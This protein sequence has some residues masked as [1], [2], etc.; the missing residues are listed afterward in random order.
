MD[1]GEVVPTIEG[2][3]IIERRKVKVNSRF[4]DTYPAGFADMEK[5]DPRQFW[6][7]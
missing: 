3:N 7:R 4:W 6:N 1:T 5:G 2:I